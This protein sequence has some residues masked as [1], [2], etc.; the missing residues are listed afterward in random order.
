MNSLCS[1]VS[2]DNAISSSWLILDLI[3]K[4]NLKCYTLSVLQFMRYLGSGYLML[5]WG[6]WEN[7]VVELIF[8]FTPP[9]RFTWAKKWTPPQV[10]KK[11]SP[12][13][14]FNCFSWKQPFY[15]IY[16]KCLS[17]RHENNLTPPPSG[18]E[19]ISWSKNNFIPSKF[20]YPLPVL[21]GRSLTLLWKKKSC[22]RL[23]WHLNKR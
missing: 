20:S 1:T 22:V 14:K 8:F 9:H 23:K 19:K 15:N 21:K 11:N 6:S 7:V 17:V 12:R 16:Y 2:T 18:S 3:H 13:H 10:H 5:V 4:V